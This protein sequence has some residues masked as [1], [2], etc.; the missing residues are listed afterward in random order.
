MAFTG[1]PASIIQVGKAIRK[2]IFDIL[3]SDIQDHEDRLTAQE[4]AGKKVE[5]FNGLV[6]N[7]QSAASLTGLACYTATK[8]FT[9]ID[10]KVSI[11][12]KGSLTGTLEMNIRKASSND[13]TGAVSVFTTRPSLDVGAASDYDESSNT[14][15]DSNNKEISSGDRLFLDISSLPSPVIGKFKI[16]LVGEV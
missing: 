16:L 12:E 15:F 14:V 2:E 4:G 5:V 11:F 8:D 1:L 6:I 9:L 3:R 7:A 10:A 13:D